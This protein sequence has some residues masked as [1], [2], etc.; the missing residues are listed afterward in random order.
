MTGIPR[1]TIRDWIKP[2]PRRRRSTPPQS[3]SEL[4][5]G[6]PW[7]E[8]SYLLGMYLGDGTLSVSRRGVYRLRVVMDIRYPGIIAAC[9]A[10]MQAVMPRK[11]RA[12][13]TPPLPRRRRS[14]A[15]SKS[16]PILFPQH[17]PGPQAS[18]VAIE[19]VRLAAEKS[20]GGHPREFIRGLHPLRRLPGA[21][22]RQRQGLSALL[23]QPGL[24]RHPPPV[25]RRPASKI[26]VEYR[27]N[28]W[29]SVSIARAPSVAIL[30]S[31]IGPKA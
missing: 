9:V 6:L 12:C 26:S 25:L 7:P 11:P 30:D 18:S 15:H 4:I 3:P 10:T 29:D 13:P 21:Q 1:S 20:S 16:W 17:G 27:L 19:L 8:Y 23:L 2:S 28:R 22:P 31:F 5:A 24:G 14:A